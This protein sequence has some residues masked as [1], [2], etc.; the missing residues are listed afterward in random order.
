MAKRKETTGGPARKRRTG[1]QDAQR[2]YLSRAEREA[3]TQR[4]VLIGMAVTLGIALFILVA[5]VAYEG[6]IFPN[7]PVAVVNGQSISTSDFQARVKFTRWQLGREL[8]LAALQLG[9]DA[10]NDT[11][12]VLYQQY[13]QLFPGN[14]TVIGDQVLNEMVEEIL[15]RGQAEQMG[16]V[17][18]QALVDERIERFFGYD[19]N[20]ETP[21]ATLTRT[22]T[23]TPIVS[24]T[25]S[26]TPTASSTPTETATPTETVPPTLTATPEGFEEQPTATEQATEEGQ[27][28]GGEAT[29]E[30]TD[31]GAEEAATATPFTPEPTATL[32]DEELAQRYEEVRDDF[33]QQGIE[34]SGLTEAQVR[35]IFE[36]DA[37]REQLYDALTADMEHSE[38]QVLARHILV[39]T[40]QEAQDVM[41]ALQDGESFADLARAVTE[42]T[43][44]AASGGE[45]DWTGRG[46][47]VTEFEDAVFNAEV[48]AVIGPVE[49]QFGYHIIQVHA[50][51]VRPLSDLEFNSK[52][53]STFTDWLDG[54]RDM[55]GNT[56]ETFSID[57]RVP[58]KPDVYDMGLAVASS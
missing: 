36:A 30:A 45:L 57:G 9:T 25:P 29:A 8:R 49:T 17:I 55:E 48:G 19:P 39:S 5:G 1:E 40:E 37:L 27:A 15:M 13:Q 21:T 10:L 12:S 26:L 34:A 2:V 22:P 7:Q 38:E 11:S 28:E 56:V 43:S 4:I 41:T 35:A 14:E 50:R 44:S 16:I 23:V 24:S 33:F 20:P 32:T 3:R 54:L 53:Q 52:R 51:E 18:D 47:F 6:V 42:D 46:T 58:D 31:A